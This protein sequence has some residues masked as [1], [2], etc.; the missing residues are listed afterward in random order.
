VP[1]SFDF[2][3]AFDRLQDKLEKIDRK[4]SELDTHVHR[5]VG[6]GQPGLVDKIENS[7]EKVKEEVAIMKRQRA[8]TKG[9]IAGIGGIVIVLGWAGHFFIDYVVPNMGLIKHVANQ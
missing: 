7:V 6:N 8:F 5:L 3:E 1:F 4:V 9:Y 2:Q